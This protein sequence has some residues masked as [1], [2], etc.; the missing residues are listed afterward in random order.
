MVVKL[1]RP[2]NGTLG[3]D[4]WGMAL[5]LKQEYLLESD[6]L[7]SLSVVDNWISLVPLSEPS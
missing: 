1:L 5:L 3:P 7:G 4:G 6:S 2:E